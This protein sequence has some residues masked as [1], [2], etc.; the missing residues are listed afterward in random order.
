MSLAG[1]SINNFHREA[2]TLV[3]NPHIPWRATT[4][5]SQFENGYPDPR[6]F[7]LIHKNMACKW[8]KGKTIIRSYPRTSSTVFTKNSLVNFVSGCILPAD[9]TS[10]D[11]VGICLDDVA[12]TD[13]DYTTSGVKILVECPADKQCEFEALVTG[14]L[15][16][17]S[18]GVTYDLTDALT[19]NQAASAKNVV[20]CT[21][22][23]TSTKGL[24][25]LNATYDV[26]RVAT[27]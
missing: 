19:V 24:F 7:N 26:L 10:G 1:N 4:D 2:L 25:V 20:T 23:I 5:K 16:T 14:T 3:K 21:K 15:V 13:S 12:A 17:T 11:H 18:V 9:S 22:F 27:T 6:F 8:V